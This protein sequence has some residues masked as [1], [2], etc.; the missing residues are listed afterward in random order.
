VSWKDLVCAACSGRVAEGRCPTCRA[1]RE[2]FLADR[3]SVPALA[4]A[5]ASGV[6]AVV[7]VALRVAG[8]A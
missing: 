8:L 7:V 6:L 5:T 1:A 2:Q 4:V 3:P